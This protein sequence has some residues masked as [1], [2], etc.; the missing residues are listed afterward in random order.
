MKFE[1]RS[2]EGGTLGAGRVLSELGG[3]GWR[4][5]GALR[6]V[7]EHWELAK[8]CMSSEQDLGDVSEIREL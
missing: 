2:W 3:F 8:S 6:P 4:G 1:Y 5:E 7:R